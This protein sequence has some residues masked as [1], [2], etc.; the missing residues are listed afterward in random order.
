MEWIG[1]LLSHTF[2]RKG[3]LIKEES[4]PH[5]HAYAL[6]HLFLAVHS[7]SCCFREFTVVQHFQI[8]RT[9]ISKSAVLIKVRDIGADSKSA[10]MSLDGG[11]AQ[12]NCRT[13]ILAS[14][15]GVEFP[16]SAW[17]SGREFLR[18]R[19]GTGM[20]SLRTC[21]IR[22][23]FRSAHFSLSGFRNPRPTQVNP[24]HRFSFLYLLCWRTWNKY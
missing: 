12:N 7:C 19:E 10:R 23:A 5:I 11:G 13:F 6:D 16:K 21:N 3:F 9:H 8:I 14:F 20:P 2:V 22:C 1:Y 18:V 15:G 17:G 4:I 24:A